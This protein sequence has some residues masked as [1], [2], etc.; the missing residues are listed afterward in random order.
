MPTAERFEK[1]LRSLPWL[2]LAAAI[3]AIPLAASGKISQTGLNQLSRYLCFAVAAIGLDLVWGYGGILSLCH[4]LFFCLGG[5]CMGMYLCMHG[6]MD[7]PGIPRALYVVSSQVSG[8]ALPWFWRPFASLPAALALGLLVPGV[9][10]WAIASLSFKSRVRGVY[11]SILTQALTLG[12]WM[13]FNR[14]ETKLCG[15]NGLTNFV[16]LAGL[17]LRAPSVRIGLYAATVAVLAL[18]LALSLALTRSRLG[19]LIMAVR[20]NEQ[21]LRFLGYRP[22]SIKTFAFVVGALLAAVGG[23]LYVPQMGIVT[24]THMTT[25]ASVLMVIWVAVGGRGSLW[26]ALVGALA[27]NYLYSLMT[28]WWPDG[29]LFVEGLLFLGVVLLYPGG[30]YQAWQALTNLRRSTSP[31]GR[32]ARNPAGGPEAVQEP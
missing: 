23:M 15:T 2:A 20:D 7:G 32:P 8:M 13:L 31:S 26:G 27:V 4:S 12:A 10:A 18:S 28:T 5:Y 19:R 3:A 17:D 16:T 29:W 21:R 9:T 14:N 1:S 30:L 24:P 25:E 6:P 22:S 11:F